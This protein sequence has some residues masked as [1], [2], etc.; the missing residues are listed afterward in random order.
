[1]LS[2]DTHFF[3]TS[4]L[5]LLAHLECSQVRL[6]DKPALHLGL[7]DALDFKRTV[8][9]LESLL[10]NGGMDTGPGHA[11]LGGGLCDGVEFFV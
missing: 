8:F 5:V 6:V 1:M 7:D 2:N 10:A 9:G 11:E 3:F 4:V